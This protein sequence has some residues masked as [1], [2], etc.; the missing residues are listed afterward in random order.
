M[1]L[2][3]AA[4]CFNFIG[5]RQ[6]VFVQVSMVLHPFVG[7][8]PLFQFLNPIHSRLGSLGGGSARRKAV[9]YMQNNTNTE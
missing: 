7:P 8:W 9:T 2:R 4:L 5:F 1:S 3:H 6:Q